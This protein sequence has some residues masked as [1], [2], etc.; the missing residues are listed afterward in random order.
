MVFLAKEER[1]K[2][3]ERMST[4][5]L[6]S[7][8]ESTCDTSKIPLPSRCRAPQFSASV[9]SILALRSRTFSRCANPA[10]LPSRN[11]DNAKICFAKANFNKLLKL[12]PVFLDPLKGH[13]IRRLQLLR[14]QRQP[15]LPWHPTHFFQFGAADAARAARPRI[16]AG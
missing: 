11:K 12:A 13:R 4:V 3:K 16:G 8:L 10:H 15:Q 7:L 6:P 2:R 1:H 14:P 5:Y 9:H